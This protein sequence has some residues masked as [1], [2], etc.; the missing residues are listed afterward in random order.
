MLAWL[1]AFGTGPESVEA[2]L[3]RALPHLPAAR[4]Q[5]LMRVVCNDVLATLSGAGA[6]G[7]CDVGLVLAVLCMLCDAPPT[8]RAAAAYAMLACRA[9]AN[10]VPRSHAKLFIAALKVC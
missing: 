9:H 6:G 2:A 1:Q 8:Q 10:T 5:H 3:R 7:S 4:F